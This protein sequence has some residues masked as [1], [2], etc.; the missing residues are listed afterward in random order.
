MVRYGWGLSDAGEEERHHVD[1][2]IGGVLD[3]SLSGWLAQHLKDVGL[4][5]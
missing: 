5:A 4:A 1:V 3:Q 2:Y